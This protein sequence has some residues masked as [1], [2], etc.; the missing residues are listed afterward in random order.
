M[1]TEPLYIKLLSFQCEC[2]EFIGIIDALPKSD[3]IYLDMTN[4]H[5]DDIECIPQIIRKK[6]K[7]IRWI[8]NDPFDKRLTKIYGY[9]SN[10]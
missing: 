2:N 10:Y 1:S 6:Y 8:V 7:H 5:G 4:Y 3:E 9:K